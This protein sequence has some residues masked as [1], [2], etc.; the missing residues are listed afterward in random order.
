[1]FIHSAKRSE[2]GPRKP[3]GC[4]RRLWSRLFGPFFD[5]VKKV[6]N[7]EVEMKDSPPVV[8]RVAESAKLQNKEGG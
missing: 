5:V 6:R 7:I 1:M 8:V 3:T 2:V 4:G